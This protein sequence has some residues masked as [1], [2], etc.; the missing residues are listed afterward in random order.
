MNKKIK[1]ECNNTL[2]CQ[3]LTTSSRLHSKYKSHDHFI[4]RKRF[5]KRIF[6]IQNFEAKIT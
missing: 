5:T 3:K 6:G 1:L 4:D 2:V